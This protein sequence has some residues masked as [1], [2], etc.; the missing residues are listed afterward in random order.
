MKSSIASSRGTSSRMNG[1]S[2]A[3]IL[4]ISASIARGRPRSADGEGRSRSRSRSRPAGRSRTSRPG[5]ARTTACAMTCAAEWRITCRTSGSSAP[6]NSRRRGSRRAA[7]ARSTSS[8]P[9]R[10]TRALGGA[11]RRRVCA[12]GRSSLS[13]VSRSGCATPRPTRRTT[14]RRCFRIASRTWY[15]SVPG[16]DAPAAELLV[17]PH[18]AGASELLVQDLDRD[19]APCRR[20]LDVPRPLPAKNSSSV[21]NVV[22]SSPAGSRSGRPPLPPPKFASPSSIH[23]GIRPGLVARDR[24]D[25]LVREDLELRRRRV[26]P[27][28]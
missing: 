20:P 24:V 23:A 27:S 6:R 22:R 3:T 11:S 4:P 15:S 25:Q 9:A 21:G 2:A 14:S 19:L 10:A 16:D 7:R 8:S 28:R 1:W 12:H 17:E 13:S 18:E 5:T 26:V